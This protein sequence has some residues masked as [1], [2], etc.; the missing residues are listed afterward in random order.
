MVSNRLVSERLVSNRLVSERLVSN[1]LVSE[2]LVSD[3]LISNGFN[4]V[5]LTFKDIDATNE[6]TLK[7]PL[8]KV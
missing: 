2:R 4:I 8:I 5:D 6:I 7:V 3:K 1:R